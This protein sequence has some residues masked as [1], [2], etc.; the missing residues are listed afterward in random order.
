[1]HLHAVVALVCCCIHTL[2]HSCAGVSFMAASRL[3][4]MRMLLRAPPSHSLRLLLQV[5]GEASASRAQLAELERLKARLCLLCL[6]CLL[7]ASSAVFCLQAQFL[8]DARSS[9]L[10]LFQI[11]LQAAWLPY[12]AEE[13][14]ASLRA[15]AGP[16]VAQATA[17]A[18][19]VRGAAGVSCCRLGVVAVLL[20]TSFCTSLPCPN[21][22]S[23]KLPLQRCSAPA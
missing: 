10:T 12:W 11:A 23:S 20:C 5:R 6:H 19:E 15:A 9:I 2:L 8:G 13:A 22:S 17:Y 4:C 3:Q 21:P 7:P 16:A 18:A 1:M 14:T